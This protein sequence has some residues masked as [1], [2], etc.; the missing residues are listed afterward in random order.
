LLRHGD[1]ASASDD[2][3]IGFIDSDER[4]P[5]ICHEMLMRR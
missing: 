2:P 5:D 4:I 1:C 3:M